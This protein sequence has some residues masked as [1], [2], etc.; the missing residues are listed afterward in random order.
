MTTVLDCIDSGTRYL[1]KRGVEDARRNMQMLVAHHLQC[2]RMQL[3]LRFDEPLG[4]NILVP[5]RDDLKKR[6]ERVPLLP[7]VL[8]RAVEFKV[9]ADR[10]AISVLR[11]SGAC[12]D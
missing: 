9:G 3:Y 1:E 2:T 4:E 10:L 11:R 12:N 5:L 8:E 6:G 7:D